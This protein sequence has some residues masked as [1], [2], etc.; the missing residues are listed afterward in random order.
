MNVERNNF[1]KLKLKSAKNIM[2]AKTPANFNKIIKQLMTTSKNN[3][4]LT[5]IKSQAQKGK[6]RV[7]KK[8]NRTQQIEYYKQKVLNRRTKKESGICNFNERVRQLVNNSTP[9]DK[10][11]ARVRQLTNTQNYNKS[12]NRTLALEFLRK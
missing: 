5:S 3:H 10:F 7:V 6:R 2:K 12:A 8:F 1:E 9:L 4:E 11:N